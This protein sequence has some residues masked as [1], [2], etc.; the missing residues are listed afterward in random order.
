MYTFS[1]KT[2]SVF[3]FDRCSVEDRRKRI[4]EYAF[5]NALVWTGRA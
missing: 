1:M 4:E 2:I 5:E 3:E